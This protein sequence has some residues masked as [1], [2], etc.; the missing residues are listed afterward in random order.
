M[1]RVILHVAVSLDGATTGFDADQGTYYV[2][3]ER[4]HE[5]VTLC[6][7]DTILAQSE[8]L[9]HADRPGPNPDGPVL[10]ITDSRGRVDEEIVDALRGLGFWSDVCVL[11]DAHGRLGQAL[12]AFDVHVV[13]VD[14]GG[15]LNGALLSEGVVDEVSLLVHPVLVGGDHPHWYGAAPPQDFELRAATALDG[16]LA[17][18]RLACAHA[19]SES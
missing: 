4:F 16:G 11:R 9:A 6:G 8:A 5:D 12:E 7:A 18:L 2:L 3:A 1:P 14:S 19:E 15:A 13:R 10:A 17:W